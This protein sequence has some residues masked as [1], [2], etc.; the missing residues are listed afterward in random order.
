MA[1]NTIHWNKRVCNFMRQSTQIF[2]QTRFKVSQIKLGKLRRTLIQALTSI[3]LSELIIFD[4]QKII[5]QI[6]TITVEIY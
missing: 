4:Q 2:S 1:I 3:E 6:Q 5:N